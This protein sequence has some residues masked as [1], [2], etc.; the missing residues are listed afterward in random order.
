MQYNYKHLL[1]KF[2]TIN[3]TSFKGHDLKHHFLGY[4]SANYDSCCTFG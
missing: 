4:N 1:P 2:R 3:S